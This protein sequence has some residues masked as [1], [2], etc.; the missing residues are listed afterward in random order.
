MLTYLSDSLYLAST[1]PSLLLPNVDSLRSCRFAVG[2]ET[3]WK[4]RDSCSK[5]YI[6]K[7]ILD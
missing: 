3:A 7:V 1:V 4:A 5:G 2:L 6:L